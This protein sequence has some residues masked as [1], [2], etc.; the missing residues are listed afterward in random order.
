[1]CA[2]RILA[3]SVAAVAIAASAADVGVAARI[4]TRKKCS[5]FACTCA[6]ALMFKSYAA[7][8]M[9]AD[10]F[11]KY[12]HKCAHICWA[13]FHVGSG[14]GAFC[15]ACRSSTCTKYFS[16]RLCVSKC[17]L[18]FAMFPIVSYSE[19]TC[20]TQWLPNTLVGRC[21]RRHC[22]RSRMRSPIAGRVRI[23][24]KQHG[25]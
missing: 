2:P 6:C 24:Q 19:R 8:R 20:C 10:M 16:L 15:R 12:L 5:Q 21:R 22:W 7:R 18:C 11:R 4:C 3:T 25:S 13:L 14:Y 17:I 23:G 1:M 9:C